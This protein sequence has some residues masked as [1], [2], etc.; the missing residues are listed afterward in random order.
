MTLSQLE[1]LL[2]EASLE[3][4]RHGRNYAEV[5]HYAKLLRE[6]VDR[7]TLRQLEADA[8]GFCGK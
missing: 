3:Y 1:A 8:D 2:K 5:E 4:I 6:E 7:E